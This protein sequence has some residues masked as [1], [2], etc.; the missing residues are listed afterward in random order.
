MNLC[1]GGST[2]LLPCHAPWTCWTSFKTLIFLRHSAAAARG[3]GTLWRKRD[4]DRSVVCGQCSCT[5]KLVLVLSEL[6]RISVSG[7]Y[8][9]VRCLFRRKGHWYCV[10]NS[11]K[12]QLPVRTGCKLQLVVVEG[13]EQ[14]LQ[15]LCWNWRAVKKDFVS[16][17]LTLYIVPYTPPV[18]FSL[19]I[20]MGITQNRNP[21]NVI[22]LIKI[23]NLK[24]AQLNRRA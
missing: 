15:S 12:L 14:P 9:N 13:Y 19:M 24:I 11:S 1:W 7:K 20:V 5:S 22:S 17:M 8:S 10:G 18:T 4:K 23:S 3:R 16:T 21:L 2:E 6:L